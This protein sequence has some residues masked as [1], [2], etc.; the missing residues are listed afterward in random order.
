MTET[1]ICNELF[2]VKV[3]NMSVGIC[4]KLQILENT[5]CETNL[6]IADYQKDGEKKTL[7]INIL[8]CTMICYYSENYTVLNDRNI[9]IFFLMNGGLKFEKEEDGGKF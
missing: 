8:A 2:I 9:G 6:Q 5:K 3:I 1:T 4:N 7:L